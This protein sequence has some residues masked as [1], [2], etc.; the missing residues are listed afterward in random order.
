MLNVPLNQE[1]NKITYTFNVNPTNIT[2]TSVNPV[3]LSIDIESSKVDSIGNNGAVS[4]SFEEDIDWL[5]PTDSN[6]SQNESK[7]KINSNNFT[8][9]ARTGIITYIQS[10]S[11]I[12]RSVTVSQKSAQKL[13]INIRILNGNE[14]LLPGG[15]LYV[16]YDTE[17]EELISADSIYLSNT[18]SSKTADL[19]FNIPPFEDDNRTELG[20]RTRSSGGD[21]TSGLVVEFNIIEYENTL[22]FKFMRANSESPGS[23]V[24]IQSDTQVRA[25]YTRDAIYDGTI[26]GMIELETNN[27]DTFTINMWTP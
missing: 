5:T 16:N 11:G 12:K 21:P 4:W 1:E 13:P 17:F 15:G 7:I 26:G 20:W 24:Q 8:G 19:I 9:K 14:Q 6:Q 3:M 10:E 23:T 27:G 18:N 2:A 25:E 22:G